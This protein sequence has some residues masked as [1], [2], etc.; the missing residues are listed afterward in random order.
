MFSI[1]TSWNVRLVAKK[2]IQTQSQVVFFFGRFQQSA[3]NLER[4]GQCFRQKKNCCRSCDLEGLISTFLSFFFTFESVS[5]ACNAH[6]SRNS[7]FPKAA[8]LS[9]LYQSLDQAQIIKPTPARARPDTLT[10][11][12]NICVTLYTFVTQAYSAKYMS[13]SGLFSI[14]TGD[15]L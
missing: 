4:W 8:S 11:F 12:F 14:M 9:S 6:K 13:L 15:V 5:A 2:R 3:V 10:F 7:S 1:I